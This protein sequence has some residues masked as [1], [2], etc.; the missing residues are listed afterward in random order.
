[1][2]NTARCAAVTMLRNGRSRSPKY[3]A[4]HLQ[5]CA[6]RVASDGRVLERSVLLVDPYPAFGAPRIDETNLVE[7]QTFEL[8]SDQSR[9][10]LGRTIRTVQTNLNQVYAA[11]GDFFVSHCPSIS[12]LLHPGMN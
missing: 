6:G 5:Y 3:A 8:A 12:E 4:F 9:T 10:L 11:L 2:R 1:V 7:H